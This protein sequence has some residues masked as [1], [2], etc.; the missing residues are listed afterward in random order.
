MSVDLLT[1]SRISL[2]QLAREQDVALSTAWRWCLRG[3]RGHVL[4][5]FSVGGRKFTTR[6]A[7]RR[8]MAATNGEPATNGTTPGD[9]NAA[10]AAADQELAATGW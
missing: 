7:F 6:E 3:I 5:S 1:E 10:I 4:E 2:N 8:W 9:R